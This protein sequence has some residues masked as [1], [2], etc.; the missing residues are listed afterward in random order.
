MNDFKKLN[1]LMENKII[2]RKENLISKLRELSILSYKQT[3]K[4]GFAVVRNSE[5][6]ITSDSQIKKNQEIEIQFESDKTFAKK[7]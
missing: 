5:R 4:R 2:S 1:Y 7:I 3:L 6:I